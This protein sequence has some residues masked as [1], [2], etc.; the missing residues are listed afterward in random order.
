MARR[1]SMPCAMR[2]YVAISVERD[3]VSMSSRRIR[4][5]RRKM[6]YQFPLLN[7]AGGGAR[8]P[9]L[10]AMRRCAGR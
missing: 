10:Q 5:C 2:F 9:A 1:A 6:P 4:R 7:I 8:F 3:E